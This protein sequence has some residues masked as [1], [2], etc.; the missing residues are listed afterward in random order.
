MV[1]TCLSS[2]GAA[3]PLSFCPICR[4]RA[5]AGH[6]D[7]TGAVAVTVVPIPGREVT[8]SLPPITSARSV[9]LRRP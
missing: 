5:A 2:V 6:P 7:R 8:L 1:L 3:G 9:M 4:P